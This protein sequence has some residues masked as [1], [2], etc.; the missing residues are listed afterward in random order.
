MASCEAIFVT[1]KEKNSMGSVKSTQ[2]FLARLF[3]YFEEY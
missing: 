3:N 1:W 2:S